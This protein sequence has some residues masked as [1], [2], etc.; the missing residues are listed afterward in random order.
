M[1]LETIDHLFVLCPLAQSVWYA[2]MRWWGYDWVSPANLCCLF[3]QWE[4]VP[5]GTFQKKVWMVIFFA[6]LW[7]IWL[8]RNSVVFNDVPVDAS[9]LF[10]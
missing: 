8:Q 9:K 2:L 7:T 6:V 3:Y 4:G 5:L 1:E 10:F